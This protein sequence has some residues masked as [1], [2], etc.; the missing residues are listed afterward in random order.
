LLDKDA[1]TGFRGSALIVVGDRDS[2][3]PIDELVKLI[4]ESDRR[5]LEVIPGADHFF[6]SGLAEISQL[7]RAWLVEGNL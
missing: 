1:L 4:G 7:A 2:F 3:A 5:R 6:A